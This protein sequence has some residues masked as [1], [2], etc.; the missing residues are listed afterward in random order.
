MHIE[1]TSSFFDAIIQGI[2]AAIRASGGR[3]LEHNEREDFY[4]DIGDKKVRL[5][6]VYDKYINWCIIDY[7]MSLCN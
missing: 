2:V 6:L 5:L 7:K 1:L 4:F 3:F